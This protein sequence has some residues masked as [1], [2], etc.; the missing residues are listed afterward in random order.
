MA[1]VTTQNTQP[2]LS[3]VIFY[4]PGGE[5]HV[6]TSMLSSGIMPWNNKSYHRRK[7][8]EAMGDYVTFGSSSL[9]T[10]KLSFWGEWEPDSYV[11]QLQTGSSPRFLHTPFLRNPLPSLPSFAPNTCGVK[12]ICGAQI[13]PQ[14]TLQNTDPFV[15]GNSFYYS[16]CQQLTHAGNPAD[17][18]KLNVGSIILFGSRVNGDFA[19]DTV[20]VIG[21]RRPYTPQTMSLDLAGYAPTIYP[22]IM[23]LSGNQKLICYKGATYSNPCNGMYSFVPCMISNSGK[24]GFGRVVLTKADFQSCNMD[25]ILSNG[26]QTQGRKT[27][28]AT[29]T[30]AKKV[31]DCVRLAVHNQN[32]LEGFNFKY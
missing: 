2:K 11:R 5:H 32:H 22:H 15:F 16:I 12:P 9:R 8:L 30:E 20:F 19:L 7:F 25:H 3:I 21:D 4:H 27:T 23:Q 18:T 1:K 31:W 24:R 6:T 17:M 29:L 10:S 14:N 28:I 26:K 13:V